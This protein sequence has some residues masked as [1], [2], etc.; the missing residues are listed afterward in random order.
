VADRPYV[1]GAVAIGIV[2]AAL[3]LGT[4]GG[5][6][7]STASLASQSGGRGGHTT[8]SAKNQFDDEK[9]STSMSDHPERLGK[10]T[11]QKEIE[12]EIDDFYKPPT[13]MADDCNTPEVMI[14]IEPDPVHTHLGLLFDRDMDA[15]EEA[16]QDSGWE[17]QSNWL[18]WSASSSTPTADRSTDVEQRRL[19]LKG[20]EQSPGVIL[21]RRGAVANAEASAGVACSAR[22]TAG[23]PG[24]RPLIVFLVG[25][26]PTGGINRPQF[27]E[28]LSRLRHI[29]KDQKELRILGPTFSGSGT[30]LQYLLNSDAIS[31][32][33]MNRITIASGSITEPHCEH[34]LPGGTF[35]KLKDV[36][37]KWVEQ[38]KAEQD[39]NVKG[40]IPERASA[41]P[42]PVAGNS[43]AQD[44][45]QVCISSDFRKTLVSFGV[46]RDWSIAEVEEYLKEKGGFRD[47]QIAELTED[48]SSYGNHTKGPPTEKPSSEQDHLQL[49]FPRNIS[50]LRSAYQKSNVFGFGAS[51][52]GSANISLNLDFDEAN[53]DEDSIPSFAGRQMPVSQDGVMHQI[54]DVL[55]QRH[56]KVVLLSATDILDEIFV[57]EILAREAPNVLV[58]ADQTDN[59]FLRSSSAKNSSNMYFVSPWPLI[60]DSQLW[61]HATGFLKPRTFPSDLAEGLYAAARYLSD[62]Q[63]PE[64]PDY[65]SPFPL[66]PTKR[67]PLW[68]SAV[69][70][71]DYWPVALLG[72]N[73]ERSPFHLP[74]IETQDK[75]E[76]IFEIERSPL[77]QHLLLLLLG[78]LALYHTAKCFQVKTLRPLSLRYAINDAD[79]R[80]SKLWLQWWMTVLLLLA[81]ELSICPTHEFSLPHAALYA[82]GVALC[83]AAARICWDAIGKPCVF[84]GVLLWAVFAAVA[85]GGWH[86]LWLWLPGSSDFF[87]YRSSYPL[88]GISPVFP[89]FLTVAGFFLLLYNRLDRLTFTENFRPYLPKGMDELPNVPSDKSLREV[90]ALLM[91][92]PDQATKYSKMKL[93]GLIAGTAFI[94]LVP[95]R[96]YPRMF[97]GLQIEGCLM[98]AMFS[99]LVAILWDVVM[100]GR[101]WYALKSKCLDRLESSSLR[102]GFSS[103]QGLTWSSLWILR[104][105]GE[106]RY[107]IINRLME[108][109]DRHVLDE[110][111]NCSKEGISLRKAFQDVLDVYKSPPFDH[112]KLVKD[113][114]V[115]QERIGYA[116]Q[117]LLKKLRDSWISEQDLITAADA[118][119]TEDKRTEGKPSEA[120][121]DESKSASRILQ[122]L[123]EEWVALVY[124]HYIRMVLLQI[125]SRLLTAA[126][127]YLFLV[128]ACT[129]YPYLNRHTLLIGLS[130]LLGVLA[131]GMIAIYASINRDPILSRATNH[132]PGHLDLDFYAKTVTMVGVPLIGFVAAQFPEVSSFLFSWIEPGMSAV[133]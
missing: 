97:D 73:M 19:F 100:A 13:P 125:R 21:F 26:S 133:K 24:S 31:K 10:L 84:A 124:V 53:E 116:A 81:L 7:A 66:S 63:N 30:S 74:E 44:D 55:E 61:S 38:D 77:S 122:Q 27:E 48:E 80:T 83:A 105:S 115:L 113:F 6:T 95:L 15:L 51:T 9:W 87:R 109:A 104:G 91:C 78:F 20:H 39:K 12:E 40:K 37:E 45:R 68:I 108:Q 42:K 86:L 70:H 43:S 99:L 57:S 2:A 17:Y 119:K 5:P 25:N 92:K 93:L 36:T 35:V 60:T 56:I 118:L 47:E 72:A 54:A 85:L 107:R 14:A 46:D 130:A 114:G 71:G 111:A 62:P 22:Q 128:W 88:R 75:P 41:N 96:L 67:P 52:Q 106:S 23:L 123:R 120:H 126:M 58:V 98:V 110:E 8:L 121:S 131:F 59:L 89:L 79:A 33:G 50:H 132:I 103:I 3:R 11:A 90:N 29:T 65:G 32:V 129:S 69:G 28:A 94:C 117:L 102:R 1:A 4:G 18:P 49:Y 127:L 101:I 64:L 16:L 34:L 82:G 112:Q 76:G